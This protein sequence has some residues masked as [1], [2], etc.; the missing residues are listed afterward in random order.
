VVGLVMAGP[1]CAVLAI[2]VGNA[3][4]RAVAARGGLAG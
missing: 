1:F 2:I 3:A 4:R